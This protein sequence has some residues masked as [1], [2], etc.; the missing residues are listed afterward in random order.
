MC[1]PKVLEHNKHGYVAR[2]NKCGNIQLAF[3]TT[4]ITLDEVQF[5][6]FRETLRDYHEAHVYL[7]SEEVKAIYI[8][9][10]IPSISL[11]FSLKELQIFIDMLEQ[12]HLSLEVNKVLSE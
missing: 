10:A 1:K 11:V 9:T 2:C 8:P 4:S 6:E 5:D 7:D 12:A 3:G